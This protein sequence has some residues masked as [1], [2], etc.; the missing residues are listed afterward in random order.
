VTVV[1]WRRFA[2]LFTYDEADQT[3]ALEEAW[4]PDFRSR[5][6][7]AVLSGDGDCTPQANSRV[8]PR[9]PS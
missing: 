8:Y 3:F 7:A 9:E 6:P 5:Y 1:D 2:E 4:R